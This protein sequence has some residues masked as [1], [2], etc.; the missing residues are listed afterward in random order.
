MGAV[1]VVAWIARTRWITPCQHCFALYA[2]RINKNSQSCLANSQ[3]SPEER[4]GQSQGL[5]LWKT[6][7]GAIPDMVETSK[8]TSQTNNRGNSVVGV[9]YNQPTEVPGY[10]C[11]QP[12][13]WVGH[14]QTGT[15]LTNRK[16]PRIEKLHHRAELRISF[17][18]QQEHTEADK[19]SL[20]RNTLRNCFKNIGSE[21]YVVI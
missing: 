8:Q 18:S 9:P 16:A 14:S 20:Y 10:C 6:R 1:E 5:L 3:P 12:K 21:S 11:K 15:H 17:V 19:R 7:K 13:C 4:N 2:Q